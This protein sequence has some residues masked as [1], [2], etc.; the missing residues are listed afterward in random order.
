MIVGN[1]GVG[2]TTA[3]EMFYKANDDVYLCRIT[4]VTR[5]LQPMLV[6]LCEAINVG[7]SKNQSQAELYSLVLDFFAYQYF[8]QS[9]L[10]I[11]DEAQYLSDDSLEC[12]R[13]LSDQTK[14]GITLM[15]NSG[16]KRWEKNKKGN[17]AQLRGRI[18]PIVEINAPHEDDLEVICNSFNVKTGTALIQKVVK[19]EGQLHTVMKLLKI[20][21]ELG[22]T[23][24]PITET[25][26][27]QAAI[28]IGVSL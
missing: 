21:H 24:Q 4:R 8:D 1:P 15:G 22:E 16:L 26:L 17:F 23:G 14:I 19:K 12:I 27:K 5:E 11:L 28:A 6:R 25:I 3:A 13:D 20:A 7:C 9:P 10:L 2:K 18:A